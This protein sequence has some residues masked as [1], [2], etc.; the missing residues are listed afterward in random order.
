MVQVFP[1]VKC[2][3]LCSLNSFA[4]IFIRRV[5]VSWLSAADTLRPSPSF[6]ENRDHYCCRQQLFCVRTLSQDL[7]HFW[8]FCIHLSFFDGAS[9]HLGATLTSISFAYSSQN[10]HTCISSCVSTVVVGWN[11]CSGI[12]VIRSGK[13]GNIC[14]E[15][16]LLGFIFWLLLSL[17][18][19]ASVWVPVEQPRRKGQKPLPRSWGGH[20]HVE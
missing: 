8:V 17:S 7:L 10:C 4:V 15:L 6:Q 3:R 13:G 19:S 5:A 1:S 16:F 18:S 12:D 14:W 2:H 11:V 20:A 9:T